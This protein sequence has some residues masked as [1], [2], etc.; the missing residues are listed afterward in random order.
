MREG[1]E[2]KLMAVMAA[3]L[4]KYRSDIVPVL[5]GECGLKNI[6]EVPKLVKIAINM[7]LGEATQDPKIIS[8]GLD[9][10]SIITGQKAI[11]TTARTSISNFKLRKGMKVGVKVTLRGFR[12]YEFLDRLVSLALPSIKDFRGISTRGF[13]GHGNYTLGLKEQI[14][15]P[16]IDYDKVYKS[17]GMN[18]SFVT[19]ARTDSHGKSLLEKLGIPFRRG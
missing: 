15:F 17:K 7:G 11:V 19:T 4:E 14:M 1:E 16:E 5:M 10:L 9:D 12:M 18:I 13:D 6:M 2:I 8:K 3:L